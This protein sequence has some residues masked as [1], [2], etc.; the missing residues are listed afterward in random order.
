M[1]IATQQQ[2]QDLLKLIQK[3]ERTEWKVTLTW[4][5][6]SWKLRAFCKN[7]LNKQLQ[8]TKFSEINVSYILS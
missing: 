8:F 6:K 3:K 2:M 4:Q 5:S 7:S 1:Q